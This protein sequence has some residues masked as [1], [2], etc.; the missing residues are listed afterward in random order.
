MPDAED[1]EVAI[2]AEPNPEVPE[3]VDE[4][5]RILSLSSQPFDQRV[6]SLLRWYI[7]KERGMRQMRDMNQFL[8]TLIINNFLLSDL[9]AK[10]KNYLKLLKEAFL[11]N[12]DQHQIINLMKSANILHAEQVDKRSSLLMFADL[13]ENYNPVEERD[14]WEGNREDYSCALCGFVAYLL[15]VGHISDASAQ[16]FADMCE[17]R[18]ILDRPAPLHYNALCVELQASIAMALIDL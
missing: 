4:N 9:P 5:F 10:N 14:A 13:C 12:G 7:G 11:M 6:I 17:A 15:Y 18:M 3:E 1:L 2:A 16:A 8:Y